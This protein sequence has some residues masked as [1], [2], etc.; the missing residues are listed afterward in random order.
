M[1]EPTPDA[2]AQ[3]RHAYEN[4]DQPL[5]HICAAHAV[6]IPTVRYRLKR[7][8]WTRRK[9]F[10]PRHQPV[11]AMELATVHPAPPAFPAASAVDL[12][13]PGEGEDSTA[14]TVQR[15]QSAVAR[16][17]PAIET[18]IGRLGAGN[19][20]SDGLEKAGRALGALTRT[21]RELNTLLAEHNAQPDG[22]RCEYCDMPPED[23][24]AFRDE[25][26]RRINAFV[27]SRRNPDGTFNV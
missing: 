14:T 1:T 9:P 8:G 12:P 20:S 3:I 15:L 25:L 4:T 13:P 24:D 27:E 16:V 23:A 6:S 7:W 10:V 26:A 5:A 21:L 18:I 17:L 19:L 11:A 2:W 22:F